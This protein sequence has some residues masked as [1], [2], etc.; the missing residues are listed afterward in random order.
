MSGFLA[1]SDMRVIPLQYL[2]DALANDGDECLRV[3]VPL[4]LNWVEDSIFQV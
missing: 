4:R 2:V 3:F 1:G